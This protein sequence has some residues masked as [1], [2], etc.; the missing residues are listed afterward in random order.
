MQQHKN[1]VKKYKNNFKKFIWL[2]V[3]KYNSD[4]HFET[5]FWSVYI[6][7]KLTVTDNGY[8]F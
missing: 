5:H 4:K 1:L 2:I 3:K 8:E 7:M 6:E